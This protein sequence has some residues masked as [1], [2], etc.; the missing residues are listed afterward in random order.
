MAL[1][2]T[3]LAMALTQQASSG[4]GEAQQW[5]DKAYALA[6]Q[7]GITPLLSQVESVQA[8]LNL[9]NGEIAAATVWANTRREKYPP[10]MPV[11]L[12]M[13]QLVRAR[14][15]LHQPSAESL[16]LAEDAL[17]QARSFVE[18]THNVLHEIELLALEALLCAASGQ[19]TRAHVQLARALKL[20]EPGGIVRTFVDI[21]PA[22]AVQLHSLAQQRNAPAFAMRVLQAFGAVEVSTPAGGAAIS[23]AG[24]ALV[25]PLTNRELEVLALLNE[26]LSDKEIA[27]ILV[28]SPLT[29]KSHV[30]HIYEKLQVNR[31]REAIARAKEY[32]LLHP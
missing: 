26:R 7:T 12:G 19:T 23:S 32:G 13:P 3:Y 11:F 31:R 4:A 6:L 17:S 1:G 24:A 28:L 20:A 5:V 21:G 27:Q 16:R 9:A 29:V 25:E 10:V 8:Q 18:H 22:L 2:H 14:V 15:L 30:H